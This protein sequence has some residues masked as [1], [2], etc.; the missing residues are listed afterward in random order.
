[1]EEDGWMDGKKDGEVENV[2]R[3]KMERKDGRNEKKEVKNWRERRGKDLS[4]SRLTT[5]SVINDNTNLAS[6]RLLQTGGRGTRRGVTLMCCAA[7]RFTFPCILIT[8]PLSSPIRT[9]NINGSA[10]SL[11]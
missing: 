11:R 3:R 6:L 8:P 7:P 4:S 5:E 9:I 1:M 10:A 2:R